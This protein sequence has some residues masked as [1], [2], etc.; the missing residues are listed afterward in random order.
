MSSHLN[1]EL[2]WAYSANSDDRKALFK[3][4]ICTPYY[5]L[6]SLVRF[7]FFHLLSIF[8][9]ASFS[10]N[11]VDFSLIYSTATELEGLSRFQILL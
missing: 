6:K 7:I 3:D 1:Y 5:L 8:V 2:C 10:K 4:G 11:F 9:T